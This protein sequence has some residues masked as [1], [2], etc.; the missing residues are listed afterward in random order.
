MPG[1][2]GIIGGI[3]KGWVDSLGKLPN[4]AMGVGKLAV[5]EVN[6]LANGGHFANILGIATNANWLW[7]ES[8]AGPDAFVNSSINGGKLNIFRT[9]VS[10][11][12]YCHTAADVALSG[13]GDHLPNTP[14]LPQQSYLPP[15]VAPT[16][17]SSSG[18]WSSPALSA[19]V[20]NFTVTGPAI[21]GTA[22]G[23]TNFDFTS[24]PNGTLPA[25][26]LISLGD[27]DG[28]AEQITLTASGVTVNV[29]GDRYRR[30]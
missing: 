17:N 24:L 13:S 1:S 30:A 2:G 18:S 23:T 25:G 5:G 12:F 22:S 3:S 6:D 4:G 11:L 10:D 8:S 16:Y 21:W 9:K 27:V 14:F 29:V 28:M 26:T 15:S 19:W 20:G 7:Y